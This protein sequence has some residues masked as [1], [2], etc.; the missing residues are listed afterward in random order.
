M[1]DMQDRHARPF[2]EFLREQR[3]GTTHDELS[4]GLNALLESVSDTG[5]GGSLTLTIKV[6][7]AGKGDHHMVVV[8]DTVAIKM[9]EGERGEA[10]FFVDDDFNLTRDNPRQPS[11]PLRE[12]PR[13]GKD[14]AANGG[15]EVAN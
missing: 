6:K 11:L 15:E 9:P 14:K 12:V 2:A 8:S 13:A 1:P 10:I 7:P 3:S 5:K 4:Q